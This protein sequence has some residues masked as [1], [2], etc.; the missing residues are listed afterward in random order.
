[1]FYVSANTWETV[2]TGQKT[3][4]QYQSTEGTYIHC[5]PKNIF[6]NNDDA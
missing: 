1:V 4:K 2:F 3:E 5:V 6:Y